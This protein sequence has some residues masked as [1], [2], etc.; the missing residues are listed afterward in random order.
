MMDRLALGGL[1][2]L[3][4]AQLRDAAPWRLASH[5]CIRR[6]RRGV[7]ARRASERHLE[8]PQAPRRA[9]E[10]SLSPFEVTH[11]VE[12]EAEGCLEE[13]CSVEEIEKIQKQLEFDE[14]LKSGD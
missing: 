5:E 6:L 7:T 8:L 2:L 11:F 12:E 9:S 3:G 14:G 13:G 10:A 4:A 1:V